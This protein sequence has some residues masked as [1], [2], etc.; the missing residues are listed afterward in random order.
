[1]KAKSNRIHNTAVFFILQKVSRHI[2][3]SWVYG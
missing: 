1:M 2:L 3:F